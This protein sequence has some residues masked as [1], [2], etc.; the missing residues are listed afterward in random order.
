[1]NLRSILF[2]GCGEI[3]F[4]PDI[5]PLVLTPVDT[6]SAITTPEIN[7]THEAVLE[8]IPTPYPGWISIDGTFLD[9]YIE[10]GDE[11]FG[12]GQ[13][14]GYPG[15]VLVWITADGHK[16]FL[17]LDRSK[18]DFLGFTILDADGKPTGDHVKNGFEYYAN[19]RLEEI[20]KYNSSQAWE[21]GSNTVG[22]L[23]GAGSLICFA[24]GWG[25][26]PCV[27][28]F[29]FGSGGVGNSVRED[30]IGDGILDNIQNI[31]KP[32]IGIFEKYCPECLG[33]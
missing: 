30:N 15:L 4:T 33:N 27:A 10:G 22:F 1:L 21:E 26:G 32:L 12:Y 20:E 17:V 7:F 31:E 29:I 8:P 24:S 25:A 13:I 16:Y 9:Y 3:D 6:G 11:N 23:G 28:L 5:T 2:S 19:E 14:I 18:D